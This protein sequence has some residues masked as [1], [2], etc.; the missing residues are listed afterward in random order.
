MKICEAQNAGRNANIVIVVIITA[1]C[2][3]DPFV[4]L[5]NAA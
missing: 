4:I 5:L 2:S 3:Q 1:G